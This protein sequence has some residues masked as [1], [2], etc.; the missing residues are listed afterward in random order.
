VRPRAAYCGVATAAGFAV[1]LVGSACALSAQDSASTPRRAVVSGQVVGE[2]GK[3]IEGADVVIDSAWHTRTDATG[4]FRLGGIP[5]ALH[6]MQVRAIGFQPLALDLHVLQVEEIGMT[7]TLAPAPQVLPELVVTAHRRRLDRV[8]YYARRAAG[9]GRFIE[10]DSLARLDAVNFVRALAR[11]HGMRTLDM[12]SLDPR[13]GSTAC[14]GGFSLVVNGWVAPDEALYLR[15]LHPKDID[16]VEIYQD[17]GIPNIT[18]MALQSQGASGPG[19]PHAS[20]G[21]AAAATRSLVHAAGDFRKPTPT[22]C[23]IVV[24]ERE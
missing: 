15:T 1:L 2:G 6:L 7:V 5:V 12:A 16:A 11:V 20:A 17:A 22:S 8:G 13:P 14:R 24:W 10:G 3:P 18:P 19:P 21:L 23:T 9:Q 4:R